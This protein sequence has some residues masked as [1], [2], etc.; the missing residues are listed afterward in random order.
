MRK[1]TV[2]KEVEWDMGHRVPNHKSK[3]RNP[4]GHRYRLLV[5]VEGP[6]VDNPDN[7]SEGMVIDFGDLKDVMKTQIHDLFDHGTLVYVGDKEVLDIYKIDSVSA[8]DR[9]E[10]VDPGNWVVKLDNTLHN[11]N[12]SVS[13]F[14]PTAENLA[15]FIF[16]R[17]SNLL[18]KGEVRVKRVHLYETPTSMATYGD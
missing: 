3:C 14:V 9:I 8:L 1:F 17:M 6:L 18:N 13:S 12:L 16:G 11:W 4:H 10:G 7:S 2:T 5:E 15:A